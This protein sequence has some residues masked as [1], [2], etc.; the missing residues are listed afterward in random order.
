MIELRGV[1]KRFG[2]F[3]AVDDVSLSIQP[4]EFLT[5]LG[6][7]GCGKTTLLRMLSGFERPTQGQVFLNGQDVTALPPNQRDVN[8]VFQGYALFPHL[9]VR[10]NIAFGLRMKKVPR[11]EIE[12]RVNE[13]VGMVSLEGFE[14]RKPSQL[15]GGQRQRVALARAIVNCPK[16]LLLDEPLS[17]LD[18]KLRSAMQ[19]ELKRLQARLGITFVFVTHDQEEALTMSN[20]IAVVHQGKI[21]QLGTAAEIYHHPRTRFVADF[22]GQSSI[23]TARVIAREDRRLRVNVADDFDL[24]IETPAVPVGDEIEIAIRPEKIFLLREP[25]AGENVFA[26]TVTEVI[27]KGA[28]ADIQLRTR[29]GLPLLAAFSGMTATN[30]PPQPGDKVFCQV[31]PSDIT[32]LS[33]ESPIPSP[34]IPGEG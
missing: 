24:L 5:L 25:A 31:H 11:L 32:L 16:V 29:S 33:A 19:L 26:A 2:S 17:A 12:Q 7:S 3:T 22:I 10:D 15:S 1:T 4:G 18:A 20:R 21:E 9:N 8:Q 6:P 23:V 28:T 13:A 14:S 27:F 30:R 34:G